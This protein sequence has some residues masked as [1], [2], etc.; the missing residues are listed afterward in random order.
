MDN[1]QV[2]KLDI[3]NNKYSDFIYAKQFDKKREIRWY[4][5]ENGE[6]KDIAQM[7]ATFMMKTPS[8]QAVYGLPQK[9]QDNRY[10]YMLLEAKHTVVPGKIPYQITLSNTA[11]TREHDTDPWDWTGV[12]KIIGTITSFML[13]EPCPADQSDIE[14]GYVPLAQTIL[15]RLAAASAIY[16]DVNVLWN[17]LMSTSQF[18]VDSEEPTTSTIGKDDYWIHPYE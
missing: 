12:S 3:M 1:I 10:F 16:D 15:D 9:S 2:I 14:Y 17:D 4:I 7:A 6:P 13:V 18:V 8:G 11:P 5:T